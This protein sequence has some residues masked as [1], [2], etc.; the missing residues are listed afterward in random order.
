MF[1][2]QSMSNMSLWCMC[3]VMRVSNF[4]LSILSR[5][6]VVC[7]MRVLRT[8]RNLLLVSC[9]ILRSERDWRRADSESRVQ[10][11]WMPR[12]PT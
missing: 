12:M 6:F 7:P 10:T 8:S 9:M 5:F 4:V 11:I 3:T 2:L 1:P